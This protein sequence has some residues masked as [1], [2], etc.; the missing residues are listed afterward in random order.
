MR[1]QSTANRFWAKV[2]KTETC[3]LWT[4][5]GTGPGRDYGHFRV[6]RAC[7]RIAVAAAK[8]QTKFGEV[9]VNPN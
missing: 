3:W 7:H 6:G 9:V 4:G 1:F 5:A 2:E 8:Q